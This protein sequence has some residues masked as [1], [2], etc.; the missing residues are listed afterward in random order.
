MTTLVNLITTQGSN[1]KKAAKLSFFFIERHSP[2]ILTGI[3]AAGVVSTA[4]LAGKGGTKAGRILD[5]RRMQYLLEG[6]ENPE[7]GFAEQVQLTWKCY[8]PAAINLSISVA[9]IIGANSVNSRRIATLASAYAMS[10]SSLTEY[11]DKV[12]ELVGE[13]KSQKIEDAIALDTLEE[14]VLDDSSIVLTGKGN[15]LCLDAHSGR[16]FRS[17]IETIRRAENMI[18]HRLI[19]S[20]FVTIN[21]F[22]SAIDLEPTKLGD[23]L[24]WRTDNMVSIRI[25]A[26]IASNGEPCLVV[27]FDVDPKF[28]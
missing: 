19:N 3:G 12:L 6:V 11:K 25:S 20:T 23:E 15:T 21:E 16:Y 18:N 22:Y 26:Q 9:A 5:E 2:A 4:I 7:I 24:G 10:E 1:L 28:V 27:D 13:N 14:K 17:D 8:I